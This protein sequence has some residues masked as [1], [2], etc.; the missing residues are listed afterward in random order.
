M[1]NTYRDLPFSYQWPAPGKLYEFDW[2]KTHRFQGAVLRAYVFCFDAK[3]EWSHI[4]TAYDTDTRRMGGFGTSSPATF[5]ACC[6]RSVDS[7]IARMMFLSPPPLLGCP[8]CRPHRATPSPFCMPFTNMIVCRRIGFLGGFYHAR[9][10][11][12]ISEPSVHDE[13][14]AVQVFENQPTSG[15]SFFS[16]ARQFM[17]PARQYFSCR[18]DLCNRR[19]DTHMVRH[20]N[21]LFDAVP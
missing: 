1:K 19:G 15:C 12:S 9:K 14:A 5:P 20:S 10:E 2:N 3:P 16:C 6:C 4:K 18:F 11:A 13:P 8:P 17:I 21:T 7:I